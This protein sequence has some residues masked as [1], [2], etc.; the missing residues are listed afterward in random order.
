MNRPEPP[1]SPACR[2]D[3][4][5][6]VWKARPP[7]SARVPGALPPRPNELRARFRGYVGGSRGPPE[8]RDVALV[9]HNP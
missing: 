8:G 3:F 9:P 1:P 5:L 6:R 7:R 2:S 4:P